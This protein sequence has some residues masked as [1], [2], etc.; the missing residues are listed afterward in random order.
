MGN[1]MVAHVMASILLV[2][3]RINLE[4]NWL[5]DQKI[6]QAFW[7][8]KYFCAFYW[9]TTI[10]MTVGFGDFLPVVI[11]EIIVVS[12]L[13]MGSCI[14]LGYNISEIGHLIGLLREKDELVN[15]KLATFRRM[16]QSKPKLKDAN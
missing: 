13:E 3:G 6:D 14:L 16:V 9:G 5:I 15:R 11:E 2:M 7:W 4:N 8:H 1:F 10:M 12:F